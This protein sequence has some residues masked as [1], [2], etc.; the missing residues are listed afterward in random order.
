MLLLTLYWLLS[1]I[2]WFIIPIFAIFNPKI[3]H[4]WSHQKKSIQSAR[5]KVQKD[6]N[7]RTVILFHAAS[8]GEFEQ[9][10]PIL[11]RIDRSQ[12]FILLSF[13]SPTV[14]TR[15]KNTLLADAVCYHPFDFPWSAQSFFRRL[16]IKYYIITRNDIWPTHL[17]IA[18]L[19]ILL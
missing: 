16:N 14:F 4:H 7:A 3:R 5:E 17:F 13:F 8:T 2:L 11:N 12:Y 19:I 6:R 15:E 18:K 9:L 1:P 10:R